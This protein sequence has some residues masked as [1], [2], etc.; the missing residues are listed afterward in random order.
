[1]G[2]C[3]FSR[4]LALPCRAVPLPP[5]HPPLHLSLPLSCY[6]IAPLRPC[7]DCTQQARLRGPRTGTPRLSLSCPSCLPL[8][9]PPSS[10]CTAVD[11]TELRAVTTP[12]RRVM[13]PLL[14]L[15]TYPPYSTSPPHALH[16]F[17]FSSSRTP[18][19]LLLPSS[20]LHPSWLSPACRCSSALGTTRTS[21]S[22]LSRTSEG[23]STLPLLSSPLTHSCYLFS[24]CVN[25]F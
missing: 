16:I 14:L 18:H 4:Q 7:G 15:L 8:L 6:P 24:H 2:H 19:L 13:K 25:I 20:S 10:L 5:L 12:W 23:T 3:G 1:M 22:C 17:Y 11:D 9:P 21:W